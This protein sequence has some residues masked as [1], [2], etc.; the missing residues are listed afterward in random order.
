[1]RRFATKSQEGLQGSHLI[2]GV[3]D[4]LDRPTPVY[5]PAS[6]RS[7][8]FTRSWRLSISS[9]A[10]STRLQLEDVSYLQDA[11]AGVL[12]LLGV[13][14]CSKAKNETSDNVCTF[15][16]STHGGIQ[17]DFISVARKLLSDIVQ[18]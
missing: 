5:K 8:Q 9:T 14:H 1:M 18:R 15:K 2:L 17:H 11:K 4:I 3:A 16:A 10:A 7:P 6:S 12:W 13:L